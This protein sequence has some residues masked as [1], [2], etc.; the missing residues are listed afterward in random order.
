MGIIW[1]ELQAMHEKKYEQI[2][3]EAED[4]IEEYQESKE[5]K[6]NAK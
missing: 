6:M 5:F 4:E 3:A 2:I 1:R